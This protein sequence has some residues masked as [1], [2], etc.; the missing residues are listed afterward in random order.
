LTLDIWKKTNMENDNIKSEEKALDALMFAAFNVYGSDEAITEKKADKMVAHPTR[1]SAEDEE[2]MKSLGP[3]FAGKLIER[4]NA[5]TPHY[6]ERQPIME[7]EIEEAY[8]AMN[9]KLGDKDLSDKTRLE[10]ERKRRELLGRED[11]K[12]E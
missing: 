10:I 4:S 5:T 3:D 9:R 1:L 6:T 8:A 11:P 2:A 7:K 12:G